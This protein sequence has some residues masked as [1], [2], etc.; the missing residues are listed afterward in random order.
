MYFAQNN[1]NI[2]FVMKRFINQISIP[3]LIMEFVSV[4]FAVLL[5]LG[6]NSYKQSK[7]SEKKAQIIRKSIITEEINNQKLLGSMLINNQ[8]YLAH[9]DSLHNLPR[10][11]VTAVGFEFDFELVTDAAWQLASNNPATSEIEQQFLI[12]VAG[13]YQQQ[14]FYLDFSIGFFGTL[15]EA[16]ILW[17]Q[18]DPYDMTQSLFFNVGTMVSSANE[19]MEGYEDFL[20]KYQESE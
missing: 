9:L 8:E 4:V 2:V 3:Q 11:N 5:A 12:E 10:E 6:L 16:S 1:Q 14:K 13:I 20:S 17:G 7:D 19:L 15:G 18:T